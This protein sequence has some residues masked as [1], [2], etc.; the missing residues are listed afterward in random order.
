MN[1]G[2]FSYGSV[3]PFAVGGDE[4]LITSLEIIRFSLEKKENKATYRNG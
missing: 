4:E 2:S 3:L 1:D